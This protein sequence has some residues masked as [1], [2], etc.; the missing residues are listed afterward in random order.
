M[1]SFLN[2]VQLQH[3]TTT[4][5]HKYSIPVTQ[6]ELEEFG[7]GILMGVLGTNS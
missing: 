2:V 7:A 5:T 3:K 1:T 4:L 6:G